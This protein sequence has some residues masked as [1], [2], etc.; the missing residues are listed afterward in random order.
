MRKQQPLQENQIT[1]KWNCSDAVRSI[2]VKRVKTNLLVNLTVLPKRISSLWFINSRWFSQWFRLK[3]R[4][5]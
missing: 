1:S 4:K 2:V 3:R 5:K